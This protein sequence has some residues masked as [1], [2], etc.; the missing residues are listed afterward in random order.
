MEIGVTPRVNVIILLASAPDSSNQPQ[1]TDRK[2][3]SGAV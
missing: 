1:L 3:L 2:A